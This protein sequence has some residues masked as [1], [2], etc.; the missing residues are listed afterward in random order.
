MSRLK[1]NHVSLIVIAKEPVPGRAKTR[2]IPDLGVEGAAAVAEA[3]LADTLWAVA[4]APVGRRV[5]VLDGEPGE[6]LPDAGFE[7]IGQREGGLDARLAGAFAD[8]GATPAVLVGMD[9]PQVTG[10][11]L[12]AAVES[13]CEEGT[14]AVLGPASDGGYWAIGLRESDPRIFHG[15]PMSA[16]TTAAR[17]RE[18]LA[19]VGLSWVELEQLRDID[20]LED[21]RA[22][23][24][25]AP[26]T[27]CAEAL[28][29]LDR[30]A[31]PVR[32]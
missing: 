27:R 16:A 13:L 20:T 21:A 32:R 25:I 4:D 3:C 11:L 23:A 6:W 29:R 2:L 12:A 26:W 31:P 19:E 14:D 9:T 1:P 24:A 18:Q 5:L 22:V 10:G 15:V 7:L 17:Q 28:R 8:S 30:E